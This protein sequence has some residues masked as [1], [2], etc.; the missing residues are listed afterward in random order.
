MY[1][2]NVERGQHAEDQNTIG[3]QMTPFLRIDLIFLT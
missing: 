2:M 1:R 3:E